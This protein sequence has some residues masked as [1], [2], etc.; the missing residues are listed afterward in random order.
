M[1]RASLCHLPQCDN[2][3]NWKFV[4]RNHLPH[5]KH[6]LK[7]SLFSIGWI[8][9]PLPTPQSTLQDEGVRSIPACGRAEKGSLLLSGTT[10]Q[11]AGPVAA[12]LEGKLNTNSIFSA[13]SPFIAEQGLGRK[14]RSLGGDQTSLGLLGNAVRAI[15]E[16]LKMSRSQRLEIRIW[17]VRSF[18]RVG[19]KTTKIADFVLISVCYGWR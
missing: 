8:S 6:Q 14:V 17:M 18:Q 2:N 4:L 5:V 19:I 15:A 7:I 10:A 3:S 13:V 12:C 1:T 11:S 16:H 9:M